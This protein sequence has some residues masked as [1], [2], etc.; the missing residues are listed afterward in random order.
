MGSRRR[1]GLPCNLPPQP[2]Q[3]VS[4]K[5]L[6]QSRHTSQ[7]KSCLRNDKLR[8]REGQGK[9]SGGGNSIRQ[10][11]E[12]VNGGSSAVNTCAVV[13]AWSRGRGET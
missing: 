9:L 3:T 11:S 12:K 1:R 13:K 7:R 4:E 8:R 2:F 10:G 6:P 5:C